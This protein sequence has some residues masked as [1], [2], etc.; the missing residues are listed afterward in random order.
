MYLFTIDGIWQGSCCEGNQFY[1][2]GWPLGV[3]MCSR[4][5]DGQHKLKLSLFYFVVGGGHKG[6]GLDMENLG[7]ECDWGIGFE[8]PKE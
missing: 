3:W 4:W 7:G 8:I 2:R 1:L 5:V 6:G